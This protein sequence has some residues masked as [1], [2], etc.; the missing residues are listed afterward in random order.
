MFV[1]ILLSL[2]LLATATSS[3]AEATVDGAK[4]FDRH[5]AACH[6]SE[7]Q[8]GVG[9]PLANGD[10][11]ASVDDLYLRETIRRGRPGRV[12]PAF[13]QLAEEEVS[14]IVA[15]IRG[16][17][18]PA[19]LHDRALR[20]VGD[21][22]RGKAL[23]GRHCAEC[24]GVHG[25]GGHGTGLTFSRPRNLPIMPPALNN[26]GFLAAAS[27]A[28]IKDTL[29]RGRHGTPMVSFL[30][31]GLPEPEI[32]DIVAYVRSFEQDP[33]VWSTGSTEK[34]TIEVTSPYSLEATLENLKRAIKGKNFR[35]IREQT[36]E[37]GL[38]AP[39]QERGDSRVVYFCNFQL[40][41]D[42]LL[43]DPRVGLYMPCRVTV[44]ERDGVVRL[45]A[46]NPRYMSRF[47]NNRDM[48]EACTRL[49]DNYVEIL[50]EA[51]L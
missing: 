5:C 13:E 31:L 25:E 41:N 15:H 42:A 24:H 10:F 33:I 2:C 46:V 38:F 34:P 51:V 19:P 9:V 37:N 6:G 16:W 28:L 39:T 48:D 4:L 43:I 17:G 32:D 14:A 40:I 20:I 18:P 35:V 45:M 27:D 30:E 29:T 44:V 49:Y 3:L 22:A 11:L 8:G 36:L 21:A 26:T 1:R 12:M 7:G 47:F 50:E 23:F